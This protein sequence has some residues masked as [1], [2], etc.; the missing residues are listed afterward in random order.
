MC[1]G[2]L[3]EV[4]QSPPL[5]SWAGSGKNTTDEPGLPDWAVQRGL[6]LVEFW[7]VAYQC[8]Y[9]IYGVLV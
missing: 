2:F 5:T 7:T 1:L 6:H 4:S 3:R 8:L 9:R